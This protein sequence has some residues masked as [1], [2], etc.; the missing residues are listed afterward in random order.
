MNGGKV[1]LRRLNLG[2]ITGTNRAVTM[3]LPCRSSL[4][5]THIGT[6]LGSLL[7]RLM[8]PLIAVLL[9][10]T[11]AI[12]PISIPRAAALSGHGHAAEFG[13]HTHDEAGI[14]RDHESPA[15]CG[16]HHGSGKHDVGSPGCCGMGVCHAFQVSAAPDLLSPQVTAASIVLSADEQVRGVTPGSLD[17][18]PRT[19]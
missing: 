19:I 10:V 18:P 6:D 15:P 3:S 14:S 7:L 5:V 11:M 1:Q 9:A 8:G 13:T 16:D 4:S 17:R 2:R 12:F